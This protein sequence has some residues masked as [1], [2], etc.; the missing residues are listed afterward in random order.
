VTFTNGTN[1]ERR[2]GAVMLTGSGFRRSGGDCYARVVLA[3]GESCTVAVAFEP[4]TDGPA[5]G[6]L[7]I[8]DGA[9]HAVVLSGTASRGGRL[10]VSASSV[11]FGKVRV[12]RKATRSLRVSNT[13]TQTFSI[14]SLALSGAHRRD[15]AVTGKGCAKAVLAPGASCVVTLVLKPRAA[16]ARRAVLTIGS[17]AAGPARSVALKGRAR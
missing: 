1:A 6:Q 8:D 5:G 11:S 2:I 14:G 10:A 15:F 12:H 17:T 7:T 9:P 4:A 16:G 13:G 3:P